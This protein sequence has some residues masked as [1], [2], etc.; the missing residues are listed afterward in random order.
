MKVNISEEV[1]VKGKNIFLLIIRG[2]RFGIGGV[3]LIA[4]CTDE[5]GTMEVEADA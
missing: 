2:R 3:M 4:R 1:N 5:V